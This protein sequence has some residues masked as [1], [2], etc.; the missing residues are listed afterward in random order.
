VKDRGAD[1]LDESALRRRWYPETGAGGFSRIDGTVEFFSRV[2]AVLSPEG[3]VV[4]LGAGRG[5]WLDDPCQWRRRLCDLSGD[6]RLVLGADVD[7]A[8]KQNNG[9]DVA[10]LL[11]HNGMLPF[12]DR[13]LRTVVA[14][15]V[16][17]HI[18]DPIVTAQELARTV[19]P[20]GWVC[21]RTPNRWGYIGVGARLV[22]NH[23]H[24]GFLRRLQPYRDQIDI[25]PVRYKLNTPQA[26]RR[27]FPSEYWRDCT[28]GFNPD[29]SYVGRSPGALLLLEAW[30]RVAPR[31]AAA[32]LHVF[33]Q[34]RTVP[35]PVE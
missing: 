8:V 34:R 16:F 25:F 26:I 7:P 19:A 28:Y 3:P 24:V 17:E 30:Q 32:I 6:G 21:A 27:A 23:H 5:K 1:V 11:G 2:Q 35:R 18:D 29:P 9:V 20:G 14:D 33:L 12:R 31:P 15:W 10:V 22:P 13:S 4:D